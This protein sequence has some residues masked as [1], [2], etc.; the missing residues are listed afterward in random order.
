[1]TAEAMEIHFYT[2]PKV[3]GTRFVNHQCLG[4][5]R[6]LQNWIVIA[7]TIENVLASEKAPNVKLA[8]Y[9]KRLQD[10]KFLATRCLFKAILDIFATELS[11]PFERNELLPFEVSLSVAKATGA[12]D[13]VLEPCNDPSS[14][15]LEST[16][17]FVL[18]ICLVFCE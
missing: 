7:S 4:L 1:M 17:K 16:A 3:H 10:S 14:S 9:L 2:I 5:Q 13:D 11:L 8:G 6:L 12:L 18:S 15:L